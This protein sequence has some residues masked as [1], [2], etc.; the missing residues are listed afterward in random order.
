MPSENT[1]NV[2]TAIKFC[3]DKVVISFGK[4]KIDLC[5]EAYTSGY[6]YVGKSFT[7]EQIAKIERENQIGFAM[8]YAK[9]VLSGKL[10]SEWS[11]RSKLYEKEYTKDIVDEVI[12]RLKKEKLIN[13]KAYC[14]ELISYYNQKLYGKNRIIQELRLK[15][16]F[17]ETIKELNFPEATELKKARALLP[18]LEKDYSKLNYVEKKQH[19]YN[20]LIR[21]G[22]SNEV[23]LEVVKKIKN[24]SVAQETN[25]MRRD[26]AVAVDK[27]KKKYKTEDGVKAFV[28]RTMQAKGYRLVDIKN[29]WEKST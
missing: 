15:G 12:I 5:E 19:V 24:N 11:L 23:A 13:D 26:F 27:G 18:K 14:K 10:M 21:Y 16:I 20:A 3:K 4:M 9:S 17:D 2:I 8:K 29:L 28:F 22:F 1:G 7:D 6:Y 25:I